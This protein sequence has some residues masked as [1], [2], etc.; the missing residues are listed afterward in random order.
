VSLSLVLLITYAFVLLISSLFLIKKGIAFKAQNGY[1]CEVS[2]LGEIQNGNFKV[3]IIGCLLFGFLSF[4]FTHNFGN[5]LTPS[6]LTTIGICLLYVSIIALF[7]VVLIPRDK[8]FVAHTLSGLALFISIIALFVLLI[9][10]IYMTPIIPKLILVLNVTIPVLLSY[11][12]FLKIRYIRKHGVGNVGENVISI[13]E[14]IPVM[15]I[16]LWIFFMTTVLIF[17]LL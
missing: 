16:A 5:I 17:Q 14:W 13:W 1:L 2:G 7:F 15:L 6:L 10:P 12:L 11:Y 8:Y 3:I 4:S 9:Y